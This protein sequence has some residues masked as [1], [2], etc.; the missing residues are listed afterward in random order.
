[1]KIQE[2]DWTRMMDLVITGKDGAGTAKVIKNKEKAIARFVAGVKLSGGEIN[3]SVTQNCF[4]GNFSEFR[5]K[6]IEY[7]ATVEEIQ[8][9]FNEAKVPE[10]IIEKMKSYNGKKISSYAGT[11]VKKLMDAGYEVNH[12]PHG[13]NAITIPGKD[14]MS[15]NGRNWTIGYKMEIIQPNVRGQVKEKLHLEFDAVTDEGFSRPTQYILGWN[16]SSIFGS[17]NWEGMGVHKFIKF[18]MEGLLK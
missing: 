4:Y 9:V 11:I 2:K 7:G 17:P 15:R 8:S 5:D 10:T 1:M 3:E 16:S 13:G 12:L 6:A 18:I 14:A